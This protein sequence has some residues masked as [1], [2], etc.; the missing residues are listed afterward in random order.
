MKND[1]KRNIPNK[2]TLI[3]DF[4]ELKYY[5]NV[6]KKYNVSDTT[7][8]NWVKSYNILEQISKEY[9]PANMQ[10]FEE[11]ELTELCVSY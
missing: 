7:I 6:A 11:K 9:K 2:E 10:H 3:N 4:K 8:K 1:H 5:I